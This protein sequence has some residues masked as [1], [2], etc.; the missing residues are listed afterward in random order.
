MRIAGN[1]TPDDNGWKR[2]SQVALEIHQRMG[3]QVIV[4]LGSSP[5]P[6][7][8]YVPGVAKGQGGATQDIAPLGWVEERWIAVG[9][10]SSTCNS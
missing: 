4:T 6:T 8:V 10:A 1:V 5:R 3:L 9:A 7:L 2:V